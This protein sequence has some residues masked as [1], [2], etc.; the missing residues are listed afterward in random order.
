V[1]VMAMDILELFEIISLQLVNRFKREYFC[2][3]EN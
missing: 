1:R 2:A 3:F